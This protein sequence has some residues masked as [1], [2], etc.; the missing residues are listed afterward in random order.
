MA[1]LP[2]GVSLLVNGSSG[3]VVVEIYLILNK[4]WARKHEPEVVESIS[5]MAC[6]VGLVPVAVFAVDAAFRFQWLALSVN[7]LWIM[8]R[9]VTLLIGIGLWDM[10]RRRFSLSTLLRRAFNR[11]RSE[12]GDLL[13]ALVRPTGSR[14]II[15]ILGQL[16][17]ID[18]HLDPRER[19]LIQTFADHWQIALDWDTIHAHRLSTPALR[20]QSL[21]DAISRYLAMGPSADQVRQLGD[22]VALVIR[23]DGRVTAEEDISLAEVTHQ[24]NAYRRG[25]KANLR[26]V[27]IVPRSSAQASALVSLLRT[28][29][30][31]QVAGASTYLVGPYFSALYAEE[32]ARHY[33]DL[34]FFA[35]MVDQAGLDRLLGYQAG[36][37]LGAG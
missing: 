23:A 19:A 12:L 33:R 1:L 6:V 27:N 13:K 30:E 22:L 16:A 31:R 37:A 28:V 32:V 9:I 25:G 18:D 36:A 5:V 14:Q 11:E 15:D 26:Y 24:L 4:L 3:F 34:G 10:G 7:G 2:S 35:I 17:Y 8:A 21:S 20:L 29:E